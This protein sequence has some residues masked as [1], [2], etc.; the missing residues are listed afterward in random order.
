[1]ATYLYDATEAKMDPAAT[2]Q[3]LGASKISLDSDGSKK[4]EFYSEQ[5]SNYTELPDSSLRY[6]EEV[7]VGG[8]VWLV[9]VVP[10]DSSFEPD[11]VWIILSGCLIALASLALALW[12]LHNMRRS[13]Q[14]QEVMANAAAEA[15]ILSNLFPEN[16]KQRLLEDAAARAR[17]NEADNGL[18]VFH[19]GDITQEKLAHY[20]TVEGI[21]GSKPIAELYPNATLFFADLVGE[22]ILL[23]CSAEKPH[24]NAF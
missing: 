5:D 12:M 14:M 4:V 1:M 21:F 3:F 20:L 15:A 10:F 8:R 24:A 2:L 6:E 23:C 11:L 17:A 18:S 13:I 16:V 19:H 7:E 22:E 9:V